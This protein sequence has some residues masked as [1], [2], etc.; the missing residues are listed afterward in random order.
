MP[1]NQSASLFPQFEYAKNLLRVFD[2]EMR[3]YTEERLEW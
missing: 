1:V 2:I 3:K